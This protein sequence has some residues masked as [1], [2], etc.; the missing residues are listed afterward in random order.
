VPGRI[1]IDVS[2]APVAI[3]AALLNEMCAHALEADP[4]ECCGLVS[5]DDSQRYRR[6]HRCRNDMTALH[7]RDPA[8]HP[9]D[10]RVAFH[11]NEL[12]YLEVDRASAERGERVTAI[13]H[14]HVGLGAYLSEDDQEFAANEAF[15]F[16]D[17]DHIVLPVFEGKVVAQG[18]FRRDVG[19]PRFHGWPLAPEHA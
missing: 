18:L 8:T 1:E 7:Q 10:G 11:M 14:S 2:R 6:V 17:A 15:P 12:D 3:P 16:P 13:Y 19:S 4:E 9:R 5:G